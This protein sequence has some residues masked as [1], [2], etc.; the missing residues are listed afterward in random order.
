MRRRDK[1]Q[2]LGQSAQYD[3]CCSNQCLGRQATGAHRV[4]G[5]VGRW[6]YPA[7]MPDGETILLLKVLMSNECRNNCH[8]CVNRCSNAFRR[9]S[10][11]PDELAD[12]FLEL[13]RRDLARGLFLS[14]A[15]VRDANTTMD[16]MLAAV[17]ALRLRQGFRGFI[18]LKVLPGASYDRVERA[19][20]LADRISINL[21]APNA[22]RLSAISPD[23][24][25]DSDLAERIQWIG[26]LV[27]RK[28]TKAK[29][30][31]TQFV[32][33]AA[34]ETDLEILRTT[35]ALY[36]RVN[37]SRAYFSAFQPIAGSPLADQTPTPLMREHRLYQCD[38][39][40]R[41][42]GFRLEEIAFDDCGRLPLGADPKWIWAERHPE[43]FPIEINTAD[44]T[45]LLRVPGIG[46]RSARRIVKMRREIR[47]GSL[48]D[49]KAM[50]VVVRRAAPYLTINGKRAGSSMGDRQLHL[51][52]L[53]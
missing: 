31:T 11:A 10:F 32:V 5:E 52:E 23:K 1:I 34:G 13:N 26:R 25:F 53:A 17:E 37:L 44:R 7:A 36:K 3:L 51:W 35:D 27:A 2:V 9:E 38:F 46:P 14:S 24:D 50:G 49:L 45:R 47:F 41:R 29:G 12:L 28:D 6:I 8:Y 43:Y 4:R 33:G 16:R 42:Y 48:T 22:E 40:F 30:H 20:E 19:A 15:V 21:E 18:H 39:L